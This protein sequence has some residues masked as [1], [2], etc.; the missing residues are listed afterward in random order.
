MKNEY[1]IQNLPLDLKLIDPN[2]FFEELID[3]YAKLEVYKEK[4]KDSKVDSSWF[5]PTLQQKEAVTNSLTT[6]SDRTRKRK[7]KNE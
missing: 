5:L 7:T 3:A 1:T 6:V 4:L 2:F